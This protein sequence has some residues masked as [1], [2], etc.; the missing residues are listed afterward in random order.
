LILAELI[1]SIN[2]RKENHLKELLYTVTKI[3]IN[4]NW[5]HIIQM[6][7]MNYKKGINK[8]GI[9]DLIIAQNAMENDIELYAAGR[10]FQLMSELHGIRI[11]RG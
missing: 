9:A 11:Y 5:N 3:E 6:Q 10:H 2:I 7:T 8:V 1:P 4:I